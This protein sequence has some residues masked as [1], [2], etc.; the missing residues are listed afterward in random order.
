MSA[1]MA[2]MKTK[3]ATNKSASGKAAP[4]RD[5]FTVRDMNRQ[6]QVV[7][8]AAKTL[9]RVTIRSRDGGSF[10]ITPEHS[11]SERVESAKAFSARLK[12]LRA[13]LRA[14][15]FVP[16]SVSDS[17]KIARMIAGEEP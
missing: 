14:S 4:V 15:G 6:P 9:G 5:T 17:A 7:L 11:E 1:I 12:A 8:T 3:A 10:V 16:P 13:T 2:D